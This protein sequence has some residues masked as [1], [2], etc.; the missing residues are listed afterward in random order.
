MPGSVGN[1]LS[2]VVALLLSTLTTLTNSYE[3]KRHVQMVLDT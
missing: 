3:D 2:V 1:T